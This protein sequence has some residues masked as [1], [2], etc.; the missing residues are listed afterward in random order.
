MP[1]RQRVTINLESSYVDTIMGLFTGS[2]SDFREQVATDDNGG[3]GTNTRIVRILR[4]GTYTIVA[5][6][7]NS[8]TTGRFTLSVVAD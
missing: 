6:T 2:R 3:N 1:Q 4:T 5:T 7:K 8:Y